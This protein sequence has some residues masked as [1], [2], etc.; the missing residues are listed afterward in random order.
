[1]SNSSMCYKFKDKLMNHLK[2]DNE[3]FREHVKDILKK[4]FKISD[5]SG[6]ELLMTLHRVANLS[7][8]FDTQGQEHEGLSGPRWWLLLRLFFE[9]EMGNPDRTHPFLPQSF[10]ACQQEYD[11]CLAAWIGRAGLHQPYHGCQRSADLSHPADTGRQGN[12]HA[13][14]TRPH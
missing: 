3:Q 10:T 13:L 2:M 1:M 5:G 14:C 11:Q 6:L 12:D 4:R 7:N 8:T 9:E